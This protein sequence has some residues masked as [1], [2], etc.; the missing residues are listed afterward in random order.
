MIIACTGASYSAKTTFAETL[1]KLY[2]DV[3]R[4]HEIE[5]DKKYED[6]EIRTANGLSIDQIRQNPYL[7]FSWEKAIILKK[8]EQEKKAALQY[9]CYNTNSVVVFERSLAD[10]FYYLTR[11][12]DTSLFD[13]SQ[14]KEYNDF[15]EYLVNI[16]SNHYRY[17]YDFVLI[18]KPMPFDKLSCE[19]RSRTLK[20][21]HIKEY[22]TI[23]ILNHGFMHP[24]F[25]NKFISVDVGL[26][27]IEQI[28]SYV[29]QI[30]QL[31]KTR[32]NSI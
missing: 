7:Y 8:I 27:E 1:K 16:A 22:Y 13:D 32:Y 28:D 5:V 31:L 3:V 23:K 29:S 15:V 4:Q 21:D 17:I 30:F 24:Y 25:T 18:F 19:R 14:L 12:V 11:Y 26:V 20:Q 6:A 2:P 9:Q 10:S